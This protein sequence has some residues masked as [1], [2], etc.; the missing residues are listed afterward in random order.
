MCFNIILHEFQENKIGV[1]LKLRDE[2]ESTNLA[3]LEQGNCYDIILNVDSFENDDIKF[4]YNT[5][6][7]WYNKINY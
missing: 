6:I 7:S 3:C 1:L 5:H 2:L 4:H